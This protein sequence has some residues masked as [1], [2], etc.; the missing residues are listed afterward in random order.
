MSKI[1]VLAEQ[2][3]HRCESLVKNI[4]RAREGCSPRKVTTRCVCD[5]ATTSCVPKHALV[6]KM[7]TECLGRSL[8]NTQ[9]Q[10][11]HSGAS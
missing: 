5:Y 9:V 2:D 11:S 3:V 7:C 8:Q 1:M 4:Q 10:C 6:H